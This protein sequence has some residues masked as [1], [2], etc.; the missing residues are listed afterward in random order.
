[1]LNKVDFPFPPRAVKSGGL[2]HMPTHWCVDLAGGG[3]TDRERL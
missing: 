2:P 1:M 3:H